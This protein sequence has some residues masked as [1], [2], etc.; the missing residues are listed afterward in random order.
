MQAIIGIILVLLIIARRVKK[1]IGF[2]K[3]NQTTLIIRMVS[4]AIIMLL[5]L[6]ASIMY[7]ETIF[8]NGVGIIA[9]LV[10]AYIATNQAQ[11]EKREDGVYFKTHVWVELTVMGLFLARIAYR[12]FVLKDMLQPNQSNEEIHEK[13]KIL[14]D[15]LTGSVLFTF[16][17]YYIGYF[18]FILRE[19][20]K[21]LKK[22]I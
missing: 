22:E 4:F 20:K 14:R 17:T 21:E 9:G 12:A 1:S 11:F 2:Q 8:Y 19:G 16:C 18:S 7:P 10:L 13:T 3:F 5:I 6:S 15:P